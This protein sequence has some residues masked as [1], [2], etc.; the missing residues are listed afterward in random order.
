MEEGGEGVGDRNVKK[1]A[2]IFACEN[3]TDN[4]TQFLVF[5]LQIKELFY[6]L[7]VRIISQ[8]VSTV[9]TLSFSCFIEN[10]S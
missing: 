4:L 1:N 7:T 3:K 2:V 9:N 8:N 5:E 10:F 6:I